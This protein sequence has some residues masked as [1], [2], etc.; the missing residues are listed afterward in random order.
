[1]KQVKSSAGTFTDNMKLPIHRWFRYSAGF[2]ADWVK[3]ELLDLKQKVNDEVILIEPFAGSGTSNLVADSLG[4]ESYGFEGHPFIAEIAN[5]KKL[6]YLSE[7]LVLESGKLILEKAQSDVNFYRLPIEENLLSKCFTSTNF[8]KL[9]ALRN[10]YEELYASKE[11]GLIFKLIITSILRPCSHVGTAQWQYVLPNKRKSNVLD[12]FEA[13]E[14]K[15]IQIIDD[16]KFAKDN[17][18]KNF[19]NIE[20]HDYRNPTNLDKIGNCVITS[21]PYP[22]NYD[23]ADATRLEMM[24]WEEI[25]GWGDLKNIVRPTLIR[26]C[27]QHS[28]SDKVILEEIIDSPSLKPIR[29]EIFSVTNE[30]G[31]IRKTKGGKKTYHTMVGAYFY[32]M[33]KIFSNLRANLQENSNMTFVIGDSAPY[34]IYV[35][36]DK[37]LGELAIDNGFESY[38]FE[39]IRDRNIKWDNRTHKV[40]LKEGL[41]RIRG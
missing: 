39:K 14:R 31:E 16:M 26:S 1:M 8:N 41:L 28:A 13:F 34:G 4:I 6:W 33:S 40:P 25:T 32:D 15:L 20:F 27:S 21:P 23:Y 10:A 37:W 38:T 12:P 9:M 29:D 3:K 17:D 2:S 24:F 5:A 30:L 7:N 35:P 18:W 11:I 19:S 22:N 36:V